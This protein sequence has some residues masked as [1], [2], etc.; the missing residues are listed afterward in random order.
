MENH[1]NLNI[2]FT[3]TTIVLFR[4]QDNNILELSKD[5]QRKRKPN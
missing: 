4:M 5:I 3:K 2:Y 1:K